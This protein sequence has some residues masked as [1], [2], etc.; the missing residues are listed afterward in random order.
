M[1]TNVWAKYLPVIR[2]V[3]KRALSCE[4]IFALNIT[5]FEKTGL[6]KKSGYKF[7]LSIKKGKVSS[8]PVDSPIASA[9]VAVLTADEGIKQILAD[10]EFHFTLNPKFELTIKHIRKYEAEELQTVTANEI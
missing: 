6:K 5:D 4:Q 9:F 1:F 7:M 10:N 3:L 2:I 8:P